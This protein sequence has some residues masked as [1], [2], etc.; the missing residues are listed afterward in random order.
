MGYNLFPRPAA[1]ITA[2]L[3]FCIPVFGLLSFRV[4]NK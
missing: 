3:T 1:G 2:F 4:T